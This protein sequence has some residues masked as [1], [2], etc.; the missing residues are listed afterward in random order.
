MKKF[1][2][3]LL[4]VLLF[5]VLLIGGLGLWFW[6]AAKQVPEFYKELE[7]SE[8]SRQDAEKDSQAMEQK[9]QLLRHRM[10]LG[11]IWLLEFSQDELNHWL[12]IAIGDA[13]TKIAGGGA[14]AETALS[15]AQKVYSFFTSKG[16]DASKATVTT[17]GGKL[18][19][20]DGTVCVECDAAGNC[21][22][23]EPGE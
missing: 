1:F 2:C 19:V 23:C 16:G 13:Y 3:C 22:D 11:R 9:V 4:Y 21:V 15:V 8:E 7:I 18:K 14:Q 17:D 20:S 6:H 12:A 5:L 10:K